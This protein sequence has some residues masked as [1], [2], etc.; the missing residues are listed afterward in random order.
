MKRKIIGLICLLTLFCTTFAW[1]IHAFAQEAN[2]VIIE[3][4]DIPLKLW[5]TEEAPKINEHIGYRDYNSTEG[6]DEGWEKWSLA[7]GNGYFGVNVF[8]RTE[9]ERIQITDKTLANKYQ[10]IDGTDQTYKYGGVNNFSETFI[11]FGHTDVSDYVRYLD[12]KTA[13]SGVEYT[14]GGVKYSREYF[15]SYPDKAL[16]IK[17]DADTAGALSFTL[18][19]T[20]PYEQSYMAKEGDRIGKTGT[21]TSSVSNGVGYIE[22]SGKLEYY[23]VDFMGIYKVYTDGGEVTAS[24]TQHTYKDTD[25]TEITDTDGTIVV[26]G[27]KSAYIVVTLGTDYQLSSEMFTSSDE[28]KPTFNTDLDDTRV[29]V[30]GDM[31]AIEA[32]LMGLSFDDAY[33]TLKDAH[34]ADYSELFGRVSL[35]LGV[36]PDDF[37]IPTDTLLEKYQNG[38][39]S[40]YLETLLFQYGRY[41]LIASSR[42]G[43]L[44]ANLQGTWNTYNTSPWGSGYWHNLNVQMNYWPAFTTNLAETFEAYVEYNDAFLQAAMD[45]ADQD[46]AENNPDDYGKDGGNGWTIGISTFPNRLAAGASAGHLGF[47]T[48]MYWDYYNYTKDPEI[49]E[50]VYKIL[51]EAA[52]Y[53]TKCVELDENGEYLIQNCDSPEVHVNGIWYYTNGTTYAQTFAYLNN[54]NALEIAKEL[55]VDFTDTTHKDYAIIQ[56]VL[57]Q[58]DKYNPIKIGLSGQIKEFREEDF[59]SSIGDDPNHRHLSMLVG[60]YPGNIINSST[61]AWLDA[62]EVSLKGRE[63]SNSTGWAYAH[64]TA[65]YARAKDGNAA[66]ENVDALLGDTYPNFFTE[67]WGFYQAD[68]NY[69]ITAGMAEMLLQSNSGYIDIL[70]ALP[71]NWATGSY[72]GLVAAGNFEVSA[73][74]ENGLAKTFNITSKSGGTASVY[75]PSITNARVVDSDGNEVNYTVSGDNLISFDTEAGKTYIIYGF[76][77]VT[78]PDAPTNLVAV[79]TEN[80]SVQLTW[81]A[82]AEAESYNVY[83]AVDNA[84]AYTLVGTSSGTSFT[85]T[86]SD[87]EKDLRTTYAVTSVSTRESKRALA[88]TYSDEVLETPYGTVTTARVEGETFIMFAKAKGKSEYQFLGTGGN[89]IVNGLDKAR[90]ELKDGADYYQGGTIVIYLL[91]DCTATGTAS[92]AGWN[93]AP[94]IDG[95]V[96]VDLAGHTLTSTAP[97]LIGFEAKTDNNG[98]EFT[99]NI[100]FKNGEIRTSKPI[101]EILGNSGIYTGTKVCNISFN[102][103]TLA[104]NNVSTGFTIFNARG[105]YNSEQRVEFNLEFNDCAMSF[106]TLNNM[107]LLND[108]TSAGA[109]ECNIEINGGTIQA[110]SFDNFVFNKGFAEEDSLICKTGANGT[111]VEIT[112]NYTDSAPTITFNTDEGIKHLASAGIDNATEE[113]SRRTTYRLSSIE[114]PYGY[115]PENQKDATF[116]LFYNGLHIN[117]FNNYANAEV[118][119]KEL[120][121]P[122]NSGIYIGKTLTIYMRKDYTH[123]AVPYGNFAQ[124]DGKY[125]LD[126]GGNTLT[127]TSNALFDVV[128]KAVNNTTLAT[129]YVEVKNGTILIGNSP[130]MLVNSKGTSGNFGYD[131]TKPFSF[132]FENVTFEKSPTVSTYAPIISV[133]RFDETTTKNMYVSA[134]FNNCEFTIIDSTMFDLS[135]SNYID[136]DIKINGGIIKTNS[137]NETTIL[138]ASD[139]DDKLTFGMVNG[140]NY[141]ALTL[142][143]D[144]ASPNIEYNI[145]GGTAIFVKISENRDTITYR[146]RNKIITEIDFTPKTSITLDRNLIYNVYVPVNA[147]LK[148]FVLDGTAYGN[149]ATLE[150][151]ATLSDGKQYYRFQ[152]ELPAS[153]AARNIILKAVITVDGIDYN[154]TWTM[155]IP[156][157]AAQ[158][159]N[160][161]N[162]VEVQL[163]KDVLAYVRAAYAYFDETDAEAMAKINALLGENYD[164]NN[165]PSF[166]GSADVPTTGLNAVAFVLNATPAIRFYISDTNAEYEFF[167]NGTKLATKEG[168]DGDGIYLEMDVYAYAM[169]E[170]ITYKMNGVES[171]SYHINS[172]YQFVT[173]DEEYKNDAELIN[174]VERFAKYC[175]IAKA[176]R[177]YVL[178]KNSGN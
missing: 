16:V 77:K 126:L 71:D 36:N 86:P 24:T 66:R 91:K 11:D 31:N 133:S 140:G 17:L 50:Q 90:M 12:L 54:Y 15:T 119:I 45:K 92:G 23:D 47:T 121:Y 145:V 148:S 21:V 94:Q 3:E 108:A 159:M 81:S 84:A 75:Y 122:N 44:P 59:Y 174:L 7:L 70:P 64:K 74:W 130:I 136:T 127:L 48:M 110:K 168:S 13:I 1:A 149:L 56:T 158:V 8:G 105:D 85:Y 82:V 34:L 134:E 172:Y 72:T 153:E 146:L 139:N 177:N 35:D 60:L 116:A 57:E 137:L 125:V 171:G 147:V 111:R 176:Y 4:S 178:S 30:A 141:T 42:S 37:N 135:V 175:E 157:Y 150:N 58:L 138:K 170:T 63:L 49:L 163:V 39:T 100:E 68:A 89:F 143:R 124:Q 99:T 151:I 106:A 113:A 152:I 120:L 38:Y 46:I 5:Y 32:K 114:T 144:S 104:T 55:G 10:N 155:S 65:L 167:I 97:R 53:I 166:N 93:A 83:V 96:I 73:A 27:A 161:G 131:G 9:T 79:K 14:S 22:L 78:T 40:N 67:H 62:S 173:T 51:I 102:G 52:R 98:Y 43:S 123:T 128:G 160:D 107:T 112:V 2:N 109:V 28:E 95:T 115:I 162:A 19:P 169:C 154:G 87:S 20:V 101:V 76:T 165:A 6:S 88:Y 129:T 26:N 41:A 33:N 117:S 18:R 132:K 118:R 29:K 69:G 61:P 142:P 103:V 164:S 25:G 156:K 80:D